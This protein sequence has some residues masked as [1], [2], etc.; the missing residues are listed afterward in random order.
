VAFGA[1]GQ[2]LAQASQEYSPSSPEPGRVE[3]DP[4]RLWEAVVRTVRQVAGR[5]A[6]PVAGRD[7]VAALAISSHGETFIPVDADGR[8]VGPAI[9]N[10]DNR[11]VA[12]SEAWERSIGR[13]R[14]YQ[15][16]GLPLHPM[17]ALNKIL[18]LRDNRPDLYQRAA[19]FVSVGDYILQQMGFPPYTDYSLAS[20]TLAFDI[21]RRQWSGE[22]LAAAG[23]RPE[24]LS[25][26]LPSGEKAGR[27]SVSAAETLGLPEGVV[28]ALG[29]HDQ[30]CGALGAG[31][32]DAGQV[33]DSAGTY[34]CLA[35]VSL[36]PGNTLQALAYNLNSYCHVVPER[37]VTLAFF[38]AGIVARWFVE[39]F[40][41]QDQAIAQAAG[42]S[43]YTVLDEKIRTECPG[44]TG[45]CMTP[46]L[47][48]SCNPAWDVRAT[49][50]VS[51]LTPA[52]S[53]AHL[54]KAIYEGIACELA[55]NVAA[56][57]EVTGLFPDLKISGGNARSAFSVQLRADLT[58][59]PVHTLGTTEA[60][61]QGAA[62]LAG[63][64]AG[65]YR[66]AQEAVR[67][68]VSVQKTY[69]PDPESKAAYARQQ[70]QYE[71]L[72]PALK[73]VRELSS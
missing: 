45:V 3:M 62:M 39:Q 52:V 18:W 30:P 50:T 28:V 36:R 32:L 49:G 53:R 48:G 7:P 41:D 68:V 60:V 73:A 55:L 38:P 24:Q 59:K 10:S 56:L 9:M 21:Q 15:I 5:V 66:D 63:I 26:P 33:V 23:I 51:G 25:I 44:P 8:A 40:C 27:L 34:E 47:I 64:A 17:F 4:K 42:K 13:E 11:A 19:R 54:Y 72:Y 43:V 16:T 46:H 14:L 61:C 6:D 67:Q 31:A 37:Y 58:G 20:R 22:I 35:A 29:G 1:D 65:V 12:Q 69:M 2:I 70:R 57:E 71:L